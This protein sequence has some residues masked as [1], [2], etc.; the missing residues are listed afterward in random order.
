[1]K[2]NL[3]LPKDPV[4]IDVSKHDIY[5]L[6]GPIRGGGDRQNETMNLIQELDEKAII[7]CPCRWDENH[8]KFQQKMETNNHE[9]VFP[10]QT[11]WERHYLDLAAQHGCIIFW[12]PCESKT[13]PRPKDQ[14][15]YAQDTYGELGSW[16]VKTAMNRKLKMVVGAEE[17]FPG[18]G[19]IQANFNAEFKEE[20]PIYSSLEETIIRAIK[21]NY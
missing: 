15:A 17:N 19:V 20:Y 8:E 18:L 3:I 10:R 4:N 9:I 21:K 16:R 6:A 1:M 11:L 5:F 13:N 2:K 14:G 12:L 7:A